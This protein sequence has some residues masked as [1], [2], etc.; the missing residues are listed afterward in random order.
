MSVF[1]SS[2]W[3]EYF[4]DGTNASFFAKPIEDIEALVVPTCVSSKYSNGCASNATRA[5]RFRRQPSC[6]KEPSW[7][8]RR[9][10]L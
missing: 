4:A 6:S 9:R 8:W 3:L 5:L 10:L 2:A 7:I 1:D